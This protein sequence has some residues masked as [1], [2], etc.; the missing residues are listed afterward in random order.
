MINVTMNDTF[1]AQK[2]INNFGFN[3]SYYSVCFKQFISVL[4]TASVP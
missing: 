4:K 3:I 2:N 1:C